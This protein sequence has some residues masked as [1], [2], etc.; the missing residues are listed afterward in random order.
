MRKPSGDPPTQGASE[1]NRFDGQSVVVTGADR[2][3]GRAIAEAFGGEGARLLLADLN[4]AGAQ[5]VAKELGGVGVGCDVTK[6]GQVQAMVDRALAEY[7]SID[8]LVNNAGT[9]T[10]HPV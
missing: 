9:I 6:A 8:I 1:M 5:A 4:E 7:G 3:M 2:G 10:M